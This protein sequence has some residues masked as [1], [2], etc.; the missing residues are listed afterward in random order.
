[1]IKVK[2]AAAKKAQNSLLPQCKT[3]IG[4]NSGSIEDRA[5]N[6][7]CSIGFHL[8]RIEWCDR[9]LC[10]VTVLTGVLVDWKTIVL[11]K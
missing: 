3:L 11:S 4:N 10:H 7:V 9:H 6:C 1:M 2:V 5:V 8:G